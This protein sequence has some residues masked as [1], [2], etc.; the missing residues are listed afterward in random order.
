MEEK[1]RWK[2]AQS[3]EKRWWQVRASKIDFQFYKILTDSMGSW[4]A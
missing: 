4:L 1:Q 2:E 3:Y